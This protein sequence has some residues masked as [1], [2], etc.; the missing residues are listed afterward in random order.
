MGADY[1]GNG[2]PDGTYVGSSS[3]EKVGFWGTTPVDQPA[4]VSSSTATATSASTAV[5]AVIAR[6]REC[7]I[8]AS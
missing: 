3:T 6:L 1:V 4:A 7:G 2:N 8:I 5:N